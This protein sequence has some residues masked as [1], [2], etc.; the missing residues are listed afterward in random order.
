VSLDERS[1]WGNPLPGRPVHSGATV[2]S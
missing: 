1:I 2:R